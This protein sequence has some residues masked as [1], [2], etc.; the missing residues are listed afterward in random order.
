MRCRL[1]ALFAVACCGCATN[2]AASVSNTGSGGSSGGNFGGGGDSPG[3]TQAD[4]SEKGAGTTLYVR[5]Q[6]ESMPSASGWRFAALT[7]GLSSIEVFDQTASGETSVQKVVGP[8][9]SGDCSAHVPIA[10]TVED[11]DAD[12]A[13]DIV[14]LDTCGNWVALGDGTAF[15]T[16]ALEQVLPEFPV[17]E[18]IGTVVFDDGLHMLFGGSDRIAAFVARGPEQAQFIEPVVFGLPWPSLL[19]RVVPTFFVTRGLLEA[20]VEPAVVYQ[21]GASLYVYQR[22]GEELEL[23]RTLTQSALEAPY[24]LPFD[25]FDHIAPVELPGCPPAA[26]GVGVFA[27]DVQGVPRGLQ[28]LALSAK[29]YAP[30]EVVTSASALSIRLVLDGDYAI[31]GVL[32]GDESGHGFAAYRIQDCSAIELMADIPIQFSWH[33]PDAPAF[34]DGEYVPKT[35][36]VRFLGVADPGKT[37]TYHF[38]LYDGY[39]LGTLTVDGGSQPWQI[40]EKEVPIHD[41]RSDLAFE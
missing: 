21:G 2:R 34:G 19:T 13:A 15:Q 36:G 28:W 10:L 35:N 4:V 14:V 9:V 17:F 24:V 26:L 30:H 39:T 33:A 32:T 23:V 40:T 29:G 41:T 1:W 11:V 22:T 38:M 27:S 25:G 37:D 6:L 18:S 20:E 3:D 8:P 7:V 5:S 12:G 31:V 16:V